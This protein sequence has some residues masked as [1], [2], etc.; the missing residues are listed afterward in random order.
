MSTPDIFKSSDSDRAGDNG[1]PV[2]PFVGVLLFIGVDDART[3]DAPFDTIVL[4]LL[5]DGDEVVVVAFKAGT[6]TLG[7][8]TW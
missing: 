2:I 3:G 6:F 7:A 1:V 5:L 4:L 8:E